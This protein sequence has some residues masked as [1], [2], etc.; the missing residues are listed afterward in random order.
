MV[1]LAFG[2]VTVASSTRGG[3]Y[4][5][6]LSTAPSLWWSVALYKYLNRHEPGVGG[7]ATPFLVGSVIGGTIFAIS[8]NH[9]WLAFR[10]HG[11]PSTLKSLEDLDLFW[12][13]ISGF[14]GSAAMIGVGL[15]ILV[16]AA[17]S[18]WIGIFGFGHRGWRTASHS[19]ADRRLQSVRRFWP[20][21]HRVSNSQCFFGC[22]ASQ[23]RWC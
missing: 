20:S 18:R 8:A 1:F 9:G 11:S 4:V 22:S 12:N 21:I 23:S 7:L 10:L 2:A 5:L 6:I 19:T 14:P 17:F 13:L 3:E 15:S 16:S